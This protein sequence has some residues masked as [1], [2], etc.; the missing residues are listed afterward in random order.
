MQ[1]VS[2]RSVILQGAGLKDV[3]TRGQWEQQQCDA[4]N[5]YNSV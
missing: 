1:H 4:G 5:L 3:K 2:F